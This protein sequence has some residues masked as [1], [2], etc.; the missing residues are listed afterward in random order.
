MVLLSF[1]W[2][3]LPLNKHR[4][5]YRIIHVAIMLRRHR[6]ESGDI[7]SRRLFRRYDLIC[8]MCSSDSIEVITATI[9]RLQVTKSPHA[10][11]PKVA[12]LTQSMCVQWTVETEVEPSKHLK[13][14]IGYFGYLDRC[15]YCIFHRCAA[16]RVNLSI[17]RSVFFQLTFLQ[18]LHPRN[19]DL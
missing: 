5:E 13:K 2:G 18:W 6:I 19:K 15:P 17:V 3:H 4:P 7:P 12:G 8:Y 16:I 1:S 14:L 10:H 11:S 9:S